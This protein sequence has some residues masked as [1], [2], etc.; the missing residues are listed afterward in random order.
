[1]I[2]PKDHSPFKKD[3]KNHFHGQMIFDRAF[4]MQN[5]NGA[6][7]QIDRDRQTD[8]MIQDNGLKK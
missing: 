5:V 8:R 7:R 4:L 6:D 1:M 3:D 2:I